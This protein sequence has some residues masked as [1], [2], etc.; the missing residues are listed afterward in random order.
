M[1]ARFQAFYVTETD[2]HLFLQRKTNSYPVWLGKKEHVVELDAEHL[3][4]LVEYRLAFDA[5][6]CKSVS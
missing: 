2:G 6:C 3:Q 5:R 4:M 1:A